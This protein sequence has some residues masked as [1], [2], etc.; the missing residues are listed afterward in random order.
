[1]ASRVLAVPGR[2][3]NLVAV[4]GPGG[5]GKTFFAARLAAALGNVP[6]VPTDDFATGQP[7]DEWFPRLRAEVVEP[8]LRDAVGRYRR[9]DWTA[10]R[11]AEWHEVPPAPAVVIEG[12]TS[13]RREMADVLA[14][15]VYV[16][17]PRAVRLERGLARDGEEARPRWERWM[18]EEDAHFSADGTRAR[19]DL[20]VDGAPRVPHDPEWEFVWLAVADRGR[21]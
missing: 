21:H 1:L 12:V 9:Y 4:D 16:E 3:T 15:A 5:A 18:A 2:G 17:A 10:K 11:L 20:V 19:C 8:L 6:V 14:F 7:G 13:A